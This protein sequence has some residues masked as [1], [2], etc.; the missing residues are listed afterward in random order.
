MEKLAPRLSEYLELYQLKAGVFGRPRL[1]GWEKT[2]LFG[3]DSMIPHD[4]PHDFPGWVGVGQKIFP[5]VGLLSDFW[6]V[7]ERIFSPPKK[8]LSP[9]KWGFWWGFD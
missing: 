4:F 1:V 7:G 2:Q 3:G 9:P 6:E 8:H 5:L